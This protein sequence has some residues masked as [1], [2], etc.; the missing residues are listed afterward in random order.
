MREAG[1]IPS[2][3]AGIDDALSRTRR[4][5]YGGTFKGGDKF[6]FGR[7]VRRMPAKALDGR[8]EE[9]Q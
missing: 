2:S 3:D 7:K 9:R 8:S 4:D 1:P 5:E 6:I